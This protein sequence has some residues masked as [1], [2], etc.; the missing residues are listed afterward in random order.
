MVPWVLANTL[1]IMKAPQSRYCIFLFLTQQKQPYHH[2]PQLKWADQ[3]L[4][5]DHLQAETNHMGHMQ[6]TG[7]NMLLLEKRRDK[8]SNGSS[9]WASTSRLWGH[10]QCALLQLWLLLFLYCPVIN[11][12]IQGLEGK[13]LISELEWEKT[14]SATQ[15]IPCTYL[16]RSS[17][18]QIL[19][20]QATGNT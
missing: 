11:N 17:D 8:P 6:V 18:G 15:A 5:I 14:A 10:F 7:G 20:I 9:S 1:L 16:T 2:Q 4:R 13:M 3:D 12:K 19:A